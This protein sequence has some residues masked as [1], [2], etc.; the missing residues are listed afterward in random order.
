MNLFKKG[1]R[2]PKLLMGGVF[3]LVLLMLGGGAYLL[4]SLP[5]Q[6]FHEQSSGQS[7]KES[8]K[9]QESDIPQSQDQTGTVENSQSTN[10]V[11]NAE[12]ASKLS[13]YMVDF[14]KQMNQQPYVHLVP[15][16]DNDFGGAMSFA[17]K[18]RIMVGEKR[19]PDSPMTNKQKVDVAFSEDGSGSADYLIVDSYGYINDFTLY[20]FT[21]HEG[22]PLVLVSQQSQGNPERM[23]YMY[24]RLNQELQQAFADIVNHP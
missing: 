15:Y 3:V 13:A 18:N 21:I 10:A 7:S 14:G 12:K 1:R 4:Q 24:P 22:Q 23:Y 9:T 19:T 11:W 8:A 16:G 6:E 17:E 5:K 2:S 20:H